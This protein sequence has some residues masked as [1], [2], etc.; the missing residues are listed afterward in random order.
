MMF[1]QKDVAVA[2]A[3]FKLRYACA[4]QL[5]RLL[6]PGHKSGRGTRRHLDKLRRAGFVRRTATFFPHGEHAGGT[7]IWYL[8]KAG[9]E[10]LIEQT[11]DIG[12]RHGCTKPPRESHGQHWLDLIDTHITLLLAEQGQNG[13]EIVRW[14]SEW[15]TIED[16][17]GALSFYL[18]TP[19]EDSPPLSCSPDGAFLLRVASLARVYY[20]EQDRVQ[21]SSAKQVIASKVKGY[22]ELQRRML[23]QRHFPDTNHDTFRVLLVTNRRGRMLRLA[24]ELEKFPECKEQWLLVLKKDLTAQSFPYEPVFYTSSMEAGPIIKR[25][26][27]KSA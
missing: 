5:R 27:E 2:L 12:Y 25:Q 3:L 22:L 17:Q 1:T 26:L 10:F 9:C 4:A 8:T 14:I 24:E 23:H 16:S 15:E 21:G 20:V 11:A 6:F 19:L 18:H 7:P 13:F